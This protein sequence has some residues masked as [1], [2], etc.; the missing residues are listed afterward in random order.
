MFRVTSHSTNLT[1]R[2]REGERAWRCTGEPIGDREAGGLPE[3]L[4]YLT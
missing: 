2:E 1:E 3:P 4:Q